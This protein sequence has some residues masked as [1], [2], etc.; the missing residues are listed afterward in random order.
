MLGDL[1]E[2]IRDATNPLKE[3]EVK[4]YMK[5]LLSGVAF[6][7]QHNIMH[8]VSKSYYFLYFHSNHSLGFG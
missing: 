3:P 6:L 7:H 8:R 1:G 2:M 4:S 5:M